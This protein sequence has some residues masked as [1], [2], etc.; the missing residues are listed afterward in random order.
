MKK[1]IIFDLDGTLLNTIK[2]L[3]SSVNFA[4]N[5]FNYP[6]KSETYVRKAI[7]N[8]VAK[9]IERC[10]KG[11]TNNP[12]YEPCLK[13]FREHYRSHYKDKTKPYPYMK[14]ALRKLKRDGYR[15]GVV[16]NKIHEAAND[17]INIIYP[18]MFEYVIG[19]QVGVP[20]KPSPDMVN[21]ILTK[22][23]LKA[24]ECYYVGDSNVDY[25]TA[26]NSNLDV[27]LV[28]YGYRTKEELKECKCKQVDT[29][30]ELYD[31]FKSRL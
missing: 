16:T 14:I 13:T 7:G 18:D 23:N 31:Y 28:T 11:G 12:D 27:V 9:L 1:A 21:M 5:S 24:E 30:K 8:G 19:D 29:V 2:D 22:M 10:I 20:K 25:E 4:L 3:Q 26:A 6:R 17:L 15:L